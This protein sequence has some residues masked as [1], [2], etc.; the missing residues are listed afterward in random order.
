MNLIFSI[1]IILFERDHVK[2]NL[3]EFIADFLIMKQQ[4][5]AVCSKIKLRILRMVD[6]F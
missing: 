6:D 3:H 4:Y 5:A 2:F 1:L